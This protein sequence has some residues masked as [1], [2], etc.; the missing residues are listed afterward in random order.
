MVALEP[1]EPLLLYIATTAEVVSKVLVAE[2]QEPQQPQVSKGL[3]QL[4][5]DPRTKTW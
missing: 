2:R 3:L 5:L 1:S 4:V